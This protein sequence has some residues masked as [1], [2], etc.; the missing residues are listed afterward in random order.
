MT[1]IDFIVI[2]LALCIV[3]ALTAELCGAALCVRTSD[4]ICDY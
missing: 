4:L 1:V 2:S 3:R